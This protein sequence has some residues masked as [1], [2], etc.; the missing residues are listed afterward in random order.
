MEQ[1]QSS[2]TDPKSDTLSVFSKSFMQVQIANK[3]AC[4]DI[5]C[6]KL[7]YDY[8]LINPLLQQFGMNLYTSHVFWACL[9]F[10]K[11]LNKVAYMTF[12]FERTSYLSAQIRKRHT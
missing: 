2:H 10:F 7:T 4:V 11:L 8:Q 5:P 9:W 3:T 1:N 6:M 12:Q